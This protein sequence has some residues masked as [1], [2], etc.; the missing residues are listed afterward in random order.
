[1]QGYAF[2]AKRRMGELARVV[3]HDDRLA[4][5]LDLEADE[6][7]ERFDEAFWMEERGAYALALDRDK[8]QVDTICSNI[9]HLL[10]SGIVP[11]HRRRSVAD[12]LMSRRMWSGWGVR[13][14]AADE[15]PYNPISY[16]NGTVWPHDTS[17]IAWGLEEAQLTA[18]CHRVCRGVLDAAGSFSDSL[19][20]VFAGFDRSETPFA[21]GYPTA[22]RPQA[23]AAGAPIL[24]LQLLLGLRPDPE[25]DVL[26][27][28]AD[29]A[30]AWLGDLSLTGV[31]ARGRH[32]KVTVDDRAI[33][34]EEIA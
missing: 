8:R 33:G 24:C 25:A 28:I 27:S 19:P 17:L 7:G 34:V 5:R 9:G 12:H 2:D 6:L 29:I 18:A 3:R 26:A 15:I 11:Q 20:E 21:V 10:W 13:T 16:H 22:S 32:W 31:R 30:P 4:A 1:V 23:W 14:M